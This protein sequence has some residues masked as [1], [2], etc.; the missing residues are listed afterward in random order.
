MD[1]AGGPQR[2]PHY[3][4]GYDGVE[5][6]P[7]EAG[8]QPDAVL[9]P[10]RRRLFTLRRVLIG[11]AVA[12][13]LFA[14]LVGWLSW[15]LPVSRALDPLPSPALVL[16][17]AD[18]HPFARRGALKDRPVVVEELPA[19]VPAAFVAIEDRRFYRHFGIDLVGIGR[20][21]AT[22]LRERGIRQ[23]GSTLTQQLAKTA[24]L[25]PERTVR[26]KLQEVFIAIWLEARLT[27]QEIL[28]RYLSSVYFGDGVFGLRA[29]S[30]HY[31]AKP[32]EKLSVGE[33][34]MLAGLVKAPSKLN[35][36]DHPQ[37][38]LKRQRVVLAAMV[39]TKAITDAQAQRARRVRIRTAEP[40]PVGGYF[41][42]WAAPQLKQALDPQYGR[43][44]VRTTLDSRLQRR[45]ERAV[46]YWLDGQGRRQ[47]ATQAGLVA[48]RPDGA[49]V[50]MVG[51]RDYDQSQFNRAV[52][53]KRQPGS[54]FKLFVYLA[55]LRDGAR[56]DSLVSEAPITVGGW[57][58]RN[59]ERTSGGLMTL[60]DAFAQSS[61]IAAV[62]VA[63]TVGRDKVIEAAQELGVASPLVRDATLP[64]GTSEMTLIELT[65]A[66][67]GVAA[68]HAPVQP[69]ALLD[70]HQPL[71]A[72][73]ALPSEQR[74]ALL[75]LLSAAVRNGTA[76]AAYVGQPVFGKTGTT[77]DH[78][79]A[80][81][82]GF[83]GDI[84]VGVWV[85]NDDHSPMQGVTGGGLPAQIWR[86]FVASGLDAGLVERVRPPPPPPAPP[87]ELEERGLPG[88]LR[89]AWEGLFGA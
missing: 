39:E 16:V 7:A 89:R 12:V 59:F 79:D 44:Q 81:F 13:G 62:R 74:M 84:I 70:G 78:R 19:H 1:D 38:A 63:E 36:A 31:F 83:T 53:A 37:A 4:Y 22:N 67:A 11:L 49:V 75:E 3:D 29:A 72:P 5:F 60:E 61:N 71:Q 55:A 8:A 24:F 30:L 42:D 21:M 41:A 65:S 48:M 43:M 2:K 54:A 18:G 32:P 51:G 85:G 6:S 25:S 66:Y 73:R 26:R 47:G 46:R 76:H 82:V 80:V 88:F 50:A 69:Y 9:K 58:P 27:K 28:S 23:G 40:L 33:A 68:G 64:L 10:P 34:A 20:A 87:P 15:R 35:P 77:Q 45:A 86:T 56:P 52:Q 57:T 17:S 14:L